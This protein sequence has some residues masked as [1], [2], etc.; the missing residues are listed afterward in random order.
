[1]ERSLGQISKMGKRGVVNWDMAAR[2]VLV[3]PPPPAPHRPGVGS[4]LGVLGRPEIPWS[5]GEPGAVK[6][7]RR[8]R[9]STTEGP[10][11]IRVMTMGGIEAMPSEPPKGKGGD[12]NCG[13]GGN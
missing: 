3:S 5:R 2:P 4:F 1:M 8:G 7:D 9:V 6:R 10:F 13:G 11:G 12:S